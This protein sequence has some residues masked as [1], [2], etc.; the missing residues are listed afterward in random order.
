MLSFFKKKSSIISVTFAIGFLL[1]AGYLYAQKIVSDVNEY[2]ESAYTIERGII[3]NVPIYE[4]FSTPEYE[5][6]L[7]RYLLPDHLRQAALSG[8]AAVGG[9]GDIK[10]LVEENRLVEIPIGRD[11][12]YYFYSV[13]KD[14][15]YLTPDAK[16]GLN[17]IAVR[18]NENLKKR[19]QECPVKFAV[20]S[21]LRPIG[22][23]NNLRERNANASLQ[24]SHSYGI[25]VDLFY[26]DYFVS[27]P[28]PGEDVAGPA[29]RIIE[30]LRTRVGFLM[31]DALSRQFRAVLME[32]LL[33]MQREGSIYV[34]LEKKQRC[35]HVTILPRRS[36]SAL[37][38][39]SRIN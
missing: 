28:D 2:L 30:N 7:R 33:E 32:T 22:Y 20:S 31:G 8:M 37:T 18:F 35:Y 19:G 5:A 39:V 36:D 10:K 27:L 12:L 11:I 17:E 23:Q 15:R 29:R 34:I 13:S 3:E 24:S 4:D 14:L 9:N 21:A 25:S 26:D 38:E 1:F 16:R 6:E